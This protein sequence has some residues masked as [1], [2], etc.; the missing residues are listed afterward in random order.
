MEVLLILEQMVETEVSPNKMEL[1][2]ENLSLERF[3]LDHCTITV[4]SLLF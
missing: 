1:D 3:G 2:L 4:S